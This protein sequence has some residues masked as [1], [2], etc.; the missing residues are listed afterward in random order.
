L[1]FS[2]L[3]LHSHH[4]GC[5]SWFGALSS[6]AESA[7]ST[8]QASVS[9]QSQMLQLIAPE[10]SAIAPALCGKIKTIESYYIYM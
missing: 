10:Y 2:L 5:H 4:S 7:A 9:Y 1:V 6:I 8:G 3:E